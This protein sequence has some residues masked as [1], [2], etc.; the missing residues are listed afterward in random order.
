MPVKRAPLSTPLI[1]ASPLWTRAP[2]RDENGKS[3]FDFMMLI[4]GLKQKNEAG[5]E[6]IVCRIKKSLQAFDDVVVYIDLN[7]RLN[8]L[9]VSFKPIPE[10]SRY[11]MLAIQQEIPEARVVAGDF[12][13]DSLRHKPVADRPLLGR[14]RQ[15]IKGR[16]RLRG[17]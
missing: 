6:D 2:L 9:W 15:R 5:V 4:P 14:I 7:T 3:Y 16:L 12:N 8:L 13:P 17:K 10:I 11:M 1:S